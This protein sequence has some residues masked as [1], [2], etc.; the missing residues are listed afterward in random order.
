MS[1]LQRLGR[2]LMLPIAVLPA[3]GLL[4]RLG[5]DDLLGRTDNAF[6]D[7]VAHVLAT[8]GGALFDNLPLL[9]AIGVAIGFARKAD[10]STAL[11]ALVGY[12]VFHAV[13]MN[14][15]FILFDETLKGS[16][17]T[18]VFDPA[19]PG[20]PTVVLNLGAQNPTRVL[21]GIVMGVVSALLWQR[22]YRTK[23]PTWLAFFS[24]RRLV[25]IVTALAGLVIGVVLGFVWPVLGGWVRAFGVWLAENSTLGAGIYGMVNRALIPLGL[26][27]IVNNVIWTQVPE[28]V[29]ATGKQLAGDLV[30]F[31]NGVQG[32]GGFEAGFY[33]I[34]MFGLPAAAIA[35]WRAAPAHRRTAVGSIMIS[36][37][38]TAFL[39]GIT[40][41]IEF[42]FIFVA[43]VLFVVHIVLTG[44]SLALASAL[45]AKLAFSFSS[46]LIDLGLYGTAA[47]ARGIPILIAMGLVYAVIYYVVFSF[48]IR[49]LNIM[50]PGREPEPDVDSGETSAPAKPA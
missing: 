47:N 48:M 34:L 8:A 35:I 37:A 28:C 49:R 5:Q 40:E 50:T 42:A 12:L 22:F 13:S 2:S 31:N 11:A 25:P 30:C 24:G 45:G 21:G 23:L 7:D 6:L 26:H 19:N 9:F 3:A 18:Q 33:P 20:T 29:T 38:F 4:L 10:G 15:F 43:P 36:A 32:Y 14:L 17:T 1:V 27:H 46:G 39:T 44:I 41:P 16:I